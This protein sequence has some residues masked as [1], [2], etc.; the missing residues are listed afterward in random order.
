LFYLGAV[1]NLMPLLA[2]VF[3]PSFNPIH[4]A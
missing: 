3:L 2:L 4:P 1:T